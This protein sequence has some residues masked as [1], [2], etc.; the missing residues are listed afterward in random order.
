MADVIVIGGGV[1]GLCC[2]NAL[3]QAGAD[4]T[5]LERGTVGQGASLGNAGWITPSLSAPLAAP[6]VTAQALRW[7][8][9]SDSPLLV[10]PRLQPAFLRWCWRFWRSCSRPRYEAGLRA[11]AQGRS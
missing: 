10:K 8:L 9:K 3:R 2:A 5:V 7:M 4:V 6:G 1:I 11:T